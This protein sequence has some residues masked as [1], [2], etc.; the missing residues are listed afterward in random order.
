MR[1]AIIGF[2]SMGQRHFQSYMRAG[3][4][5]VAIS[6]WKPEVVRNMVPDFPENHVYQDHRSLLASEEV[7]MVSVVTNGP[8]H[9]SITMDASEAGVPNILCEKPMAL[10][11][12]SADN[13]IKTCERN[14]TRLAINHIRRWSTNYGRLHQMLGEGIIGDVRH[15]YFSCGSTGLGNF[16]IHFFDTARFL[17]GSEPEWALGFIDKTGTPNPRG[18]QFSDPGG[19]GIIQFKNGVRFFLDTSEDTGVQYTFQIVGTYGRIIIDELND[20]WQIRARRGSTRDLPLTRYGADMDPVPFTS[21]CRFDIVGLTAKCLAEL[22]EGKTISCGGRDGKASL[23]MVIALHLSDES[24]N[25]KVPF[26]LP[27]RVFTKEIVI[28]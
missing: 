14:R 26:P 12:A 13:V 15:L 18:A 7:D 28:A 4:D 19:Y 25:V 20:L 16:A 24:G 11:L 5:V 2:G 6:D 10:S 17:T 21:D 22:A 27:Q 23:E 8:S 9:A 1:A 3:I